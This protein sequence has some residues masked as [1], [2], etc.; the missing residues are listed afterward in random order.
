[1]NKKIIGL[2]LV[3]TGLLVACG[4]GKGLDTNQN[5]HGETQSDTQNKSATTYDNSDVMKKINKGAFLKPSDSYVYQGIKYTIHSMELTKELG[6]HPKDKVNYLTD[7]VDANGNYTG[8]SDFFWVT[9]TIENTTKKTIEV[10]PSSNRIAEINEKGY[11][12]TSGDAIYMSP[13]EQGRSPAEE[14]LCS[15]KAGESR[16]EEIGYLFTE[17][18]SFQKNNLYYEIGSTG[19]D[20]NN[21]DNR[22]Y[23]LGD[24][25]NAK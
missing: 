24:F 21:P 18:D 1:M 10:S 14:Y 8:T 12:A 2:I 23:K 20:I 22:F 4:N 17:D 6:N 16:E 9:L 11:G 13:C 7:D 15:L 19:S 3:M 25:T 5:S